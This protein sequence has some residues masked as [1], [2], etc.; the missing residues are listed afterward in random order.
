MCGLC[1]CVGMSEAMKRHYELLLLYASGV[2]P[3]DVIHIYGVS[4]STAYRW[5]L[6]YQEARKELRRMIQT[7][8]SVSPRK[9]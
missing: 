4:R 2:K 3:V 9:E 7:A 8:F 5:H 1:G 6:L